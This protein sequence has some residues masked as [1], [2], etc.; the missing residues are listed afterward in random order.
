MIFVWHREWNN[1]NDMLRRCASADACVMESDRGA[2][3][4]VRVYKNDIKFIYQCWW[5]GFAVIASFHYCDSIELGAITSSSKT[6]ERDWLW[7]AN[8]SIYFSTWLKLL[9]F[10][11]WLA[12]TTCVM[13]IHPCKRHM[14]K[15]RN[16]HFKSFA[17]FI[18]HASDDVVWHFLQH[19][20]IISVL[21]YAL[22]YDSY[23]R[24]HSQQQQQHKPNQQ[25][26]FK[27]DKNGPKT[28]EPFQIQRK[29]R[30]KH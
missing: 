11:L 30:T 23:R 10:D 25:K 14:K 18:I 28:S 19:E 9:E 3:R 29:H 1:Y 8:F 7:C 6:R 16:I 27:V 21:E 2:A 13:H 24:P 15:R 17:C 12:K 4:R 22:M 26:I 20:H 5:L